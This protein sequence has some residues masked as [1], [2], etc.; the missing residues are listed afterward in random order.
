MSA[1]KL[2]K[3]QSL[4]IDLYEKLSPSLAFKRAVKEGPKGKQRIFEIDTEQLTIIL[5]LLKMY[6]KF[7]FIK[8]CL[9]GCQKIQLTE[10]FK[11][12]A[13]VFIK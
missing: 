9:H 2:L 13:F 12:F 6:R 5:N 10:F 4:F 3:L 11:K 8:V 1:A 7:T